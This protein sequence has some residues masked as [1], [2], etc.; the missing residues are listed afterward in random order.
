MSL[1]YEKV[2]FFK[3]KHL[4]ESVAAPRILSL[5]FYVVLHKIGPI[6]LIDYSL[7]VLLVIPG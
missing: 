1:N 4:L 2:N 7:L 3:T 5:R 6:H